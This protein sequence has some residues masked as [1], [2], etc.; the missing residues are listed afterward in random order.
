MKD[1][2]G[3]LKG[4]RATEVEWAKDPVTKRYTSFV[5]KPESEF[6]ID[7][8]YAFSGNGLLHVQ[9]KGLVE[10]L[11]IQLDPRLNL[12]GND[13]EYKTNQDKIFTCGDA[14]RGQ[15][16]VVWAITEGRKCAEKV[17]IYMKED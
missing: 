15:S 9:H 6:I 5:E 8:D 2:Q 11:D 17:N 12:I 4:V 14:R 13:T 16:L 1:E 7:C 10:A 3:N